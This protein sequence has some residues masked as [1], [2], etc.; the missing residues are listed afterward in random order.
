VIAGIDEAGYGPRLGPLVIGCAVFRAPTDKADMVDMADMA[1]MAGGEAPMDL[2]RALHPT[3]VRSKAKSDTTRIPI[4]D[5]KKLKLANTAP[6]PL[7]HLERGILPSLG[8]LDRKP[9]TGA[10]LLEAMGIGDQPADDASPASTALTGD[11]IDILTNALRR[12]MRLANIELL[13]LTCAA[14]DAGRFNQA[15][16][17]LGPKSEV[18]FNTVGRFLRGLW[19]RWG[20]ES[21]MVAVDRQGG[22][23]RYGAP[24]A[25]A[26]PGVIVT[27][28]TEGETVS[29]Y[30]IE[31]R[32][33]AAQ[34]RRMTVRFEVSGDDHHLPVAL[35]SMAAKLVRERLM[36]RFNAHWA[37]RAPQVRPTAGYGLD[38]RRW[39]NEIRPL[40]S[41]DELRALVRRA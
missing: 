31:S 36:M 14:L 20:A 18:S 4:D 10:E 27:P 7:V 25:G 40:I 39:I 19:K 22:R 41:E 17:E 8:L 28:V 29:V 35:A 33:G 30:R 3:V 15:L 38:A 34:R 32:G 13:G 11:Q 24:L 5:S 26:I 16:T 2:W 1:D 9:S 6:N 12:A 21:P 23:K 37:G